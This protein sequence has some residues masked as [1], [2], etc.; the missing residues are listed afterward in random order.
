[1]KP[2]EEEKMLEIA[3]PIM[4]GILRGFSENDYAEYS[5]DFGDVMLKAHEKA[6]FEETRDFIV[7][8]SGRYVSKGDSQVLEQGSYVIVVSKARFTKEDEVLVK[9]VFSADDPKHKVMGLWF[10]SPKIR[11]SL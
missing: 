4:D 7:S 3:G 1:M 11:E 9:V 2:D 10:D 6:K 5:K 8:K